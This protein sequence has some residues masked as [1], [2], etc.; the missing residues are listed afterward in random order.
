MSRRHAAL[1]VLA[2]LAALTLLVPAS[3]KAATFYG[4]V[5]PG[6][7]I[8]LERANGTKV[9]RIQDGTHT[10]VIRDRSVNHNFHLLG[11]GIDKKTSV[12]F[13]GR[14][15]WRVTLDVGVHRYRCDPHRAM[16]R[17]R[18]TVY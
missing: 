1:A 10:F 5:G 15:R 7:T 11:P 9:R 6:M 4:R 2:L 14:R 3:A 18:F 8:T 13:T 12:A 17:G 16:M